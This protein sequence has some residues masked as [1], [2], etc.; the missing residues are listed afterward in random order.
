MKV[1]GNLATAVNVGSG[2]M[3][4]AASMALPSF[5]LTDLAGIVSRTVTSARAQGRDYMAQSRAAAM[6]V[7]AVRPDFSYGQALEAVERLRT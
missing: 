1:M 7:I 6:A 2:F 3:S 5:A 4:Q